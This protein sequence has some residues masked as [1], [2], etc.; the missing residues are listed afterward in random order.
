MGEPRSLSRENHQHHRTSCAEEGPLPGDPEI[1]RLFG[2]C[3]DPQQVG[4][5]DPLATYDNRV[6]PGKGFG[7]QP[8]DEME[9]FCCALSF[10]PMARTAL[11]AHQDTRIDAGP[12]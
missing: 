6:E 1:A 4:F 3:D 5:S 7:R 11:A 9:M 8:H 10:Q 12:F 2:R